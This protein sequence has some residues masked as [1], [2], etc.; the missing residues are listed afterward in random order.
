MAH[1]TDRRGH[2]AFVTSNFWPEP[3]G[4]SQTVSEYAEFLS[5]QRVPVRVATSMPYYPQWQIWPEYRGRIWCSEQHNGIRIFRSWHYVRP[6]VSTV[7]RILHETTLSLFALPNMIRVLHRAHVAYVVSPALSYAVMGLTV[8]KLLG[9]RSVL[10]VKDVM[11]DAAV[12]LGMLRNTAVI[13]VSRWLA[14]VAYA[15]ADEIHTLGEGMR[16]RITRQMS[17]PSKITIVPDTVD[18]D[19]LAPV[20]D[21]NEF[22]SR[23]VPE[24]V[25]AVLHTGN[26]GKKQDL[27]LLLRAAARLRDDPSIHFYVFGDGAVK[28]DFLRRREELGLENVSHFPLQD[29]WMLRHMLSG[30]DAVLIS[31]LPEVVDIV[32][33]SKLLTAL[34]AGA[35]IVAACA[36]DSETAHLVAESRGGVVVPPGDDGS[37]AEMLQSIKAGEVPTSDYRRR[38]RDFAVRRFDRRAIYGPLVEL[39]FG[40][41]LKRAGNE[42]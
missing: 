14:R 25:F 2:A 29:R 33:P 16:N 22:R 12:E 38:A 39:H 40:T 5:G 11:P 9:V 17:E 18:A 21:G 26:M 36:A 10:V 27:D 1:E 34:A 30:A 42:Q 19:E 7:T 8:S 32:V 41:D 24:G 3:T 37:L 35:M 15:L 6:H 23:F 4:T 31:Q 20:Q 13:R 28:S